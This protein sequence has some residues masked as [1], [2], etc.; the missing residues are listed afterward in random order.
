MNKFVYL[1]KK[2]YLLQIIHYLIKILS[3][4][5][6]SQLNWE[7]GLDINIYHFSYTICPCYIYLMLTPF[8]WWISI[9]KMRVNM[10]TT[11]K[12]LRIQY[13]SFPTEKQSTLIIKLCCQS[14]LLCPVLYDG[15]SIKL[16]LSRM[17][18][19]WFYQIPERLTITT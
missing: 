10:Q 5:L 17:N 3:S 4:K 9:C 12:T 14:H 16:F 18:N 7:A 15:W 11:L 8:V 6:G 19:S 13:M 2:S 1:H